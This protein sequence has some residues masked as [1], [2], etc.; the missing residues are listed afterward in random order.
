MGA[1][2][3]IIGGAIGSVGT[4]LQSQEARKQKNQLKD[5]ANTPGLDIDSEI[6]NAY[7]AYEKSLPEAQ[8]IT[9]QV[10]QGNS[11]A[12]R[13]LLSSGIPGYEG[14]QAQDLANIGSEL[15]GE[16]P[17]DVQAAIERATAAHSV[18][19]GYGGTQVGRNL[20]ARDLGRTSLDLMQRGGTDLSRVL[21]TTPLPG[22]VGVQSL[23]GPSISDRIG[24]RS[25][26]RT[27]KLQMLTK[28]VLSPSDMQVISQFLVEQGAAL[29]GAGM[30]SMGA[31][32]GSSGA[33]SGGG[34]LNIQP[35]GANYSSSFGG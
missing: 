34:G 7:A 11:A 20:T 3:A 13:Q 15:R 29:Q 32:F 18:A 22:L 2:G 33:S 9:G 23:M 17:P 5:L 12:M 26:E 8:R 35:G 4:L 14:L 25:N 10:N 16:L 1:Y 28:S 21:Q 19:G 31:G 30:G 6:A 27:Q 24:I